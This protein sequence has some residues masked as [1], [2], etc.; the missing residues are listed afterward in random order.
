ML[1][2]APE[3]SNGEKLQ[4]YSESEAGYSHA[5]HLHNDY[6]IRLYFSNFK[7]NLDIF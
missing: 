1:N 6:F 5:S 2:R 3:S 7:R 4:Y